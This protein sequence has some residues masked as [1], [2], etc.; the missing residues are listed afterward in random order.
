ML[1]EHHQGRC[2]HHLSGQSTPVPEHPFREAVSP[3]VQPEPS[4]AQL[5]AIPSS[6]ITGYVREEADPQLTTA[7]LQVVRES[8]DVSPEPPL[9]QSELVCPILLSS[10]HLAFTVLCFSHES[11][12]VTWSGWAGPYHEASGWKKSCYHIFSCNQ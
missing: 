11:C 2:L 8:N 3:N 10:S 4:L 7:S 1:F 12:S 9:L 6:P 5:E